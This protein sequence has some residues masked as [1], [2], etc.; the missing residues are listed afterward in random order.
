[1]G[2]VVIRKAEEAPVVPFSGVSGAGSQGQVQKI[3]RASCRE[4]V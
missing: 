3:G 4:R 1:M 2:K